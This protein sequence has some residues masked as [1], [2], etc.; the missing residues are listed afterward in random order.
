MNGTVLLGPSG[1]DPLPG[2][3]FKV[4]QVLDDHKSVARCAPTSIGKNT[5]VAITVK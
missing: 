5:R 1:E 3:A 2:G 4:V